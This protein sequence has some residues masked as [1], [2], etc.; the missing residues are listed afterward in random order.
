MTPEQYRH[1]LNRLSSALKSARQTYDYRIPVP[2][3]AINVGALE[4][5]QED[6]RVA[7]KHVQAILQAEREAR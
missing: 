3:I 2:G 1:H 7:L 4:D 5:I 6:L